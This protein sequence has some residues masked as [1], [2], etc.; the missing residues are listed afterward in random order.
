[1]SSQVANR[2]ALDFG[3][4]GVGVV[5][6]TRITNDANF[7]GE[8]VTGVA[9]RSGELDERFYVVALAYDEVARRRPLS[10]CSGVPVRRDID[11]RRRETT[12]ATPERHGRWQA[13]RYGY[14]SVPLRL[15]GGWR[16]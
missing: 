15:V 7:D 13:Y 1:M 4:Q 2:S 3:A 5:G 14:T 12:L 8:A 11:R 9:D 10:P 6:I 16:R